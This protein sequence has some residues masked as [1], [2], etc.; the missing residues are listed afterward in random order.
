MSHVLGRDGVLERGHLDLQS[1]DRTRERDVSFPTV[2]EKGVPTSGH[3]G[4]Q[5]QGSI[6]GART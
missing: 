4:K 1:S 5:R 2:L 3:H 6:T